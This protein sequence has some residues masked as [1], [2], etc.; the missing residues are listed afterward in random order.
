VFSGGSSQWTTV[1]TGMY[2]NDGRVGIST[3]TL[4]T[5]YDFQV[6]S[7]GKLSITNLTT[8]ITAI[9]T[10]ND[11]SGLTNTR[12]SLYGHTNSITP[13]TIE[14]SCSSGTGIH[15]FLTN[16]GGAGISEKM[17]LTFVGR[18]GINTTVPGFL[19]EI[20][21]TGGTTGS[22]SQR[23]FN[24]STALTLGTTTFSNVSMKVNGTILTTTTITTSSDSRIKEDIQDINDDSALQSILVIE[25]KTYKYIDKI[26]KGDKKVYGFIAQQIRTI[27]PEVTDIEKSYIPNIMLLADYNDGIITLPSSPTKV[28]IKLNDKIKCYDKDDKEICV[29]VEEV[30]DEITFRIKPLGDEETSYVDDKIFVSGTEIDDFHILDKSY[31]F[32]LN[33]CATQEL[34]QRIISQ[35]ERI[36]ELETKMTDILK[37]LSL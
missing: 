34:H 19:L 21:T 36:R 17:R 7:G 12:I 31:I 27:I 28:I 11:V 20:G 29:E 25:P 24:G 37:Y 14:Y 35:E 32:T 8:N 33:V 2:Y 18:L 6:G 26:E 4:N 10:D 15:R 5:N 1:G 23:Y 22:I 30:I 16:N 3:S 13:G 9:G